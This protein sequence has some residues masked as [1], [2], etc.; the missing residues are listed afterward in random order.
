MK[1]I[2]DDLSFIYLVVQMV[3]DKKD[4]NLSSASCSALGEIARKA[5]LPLVDGQFTEVEEERME[6]DSG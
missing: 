2:V 1:V 4:L 5:P 3:G 6:S